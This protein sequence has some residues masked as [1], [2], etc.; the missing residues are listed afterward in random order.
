MTLGHVDV[1]ERASHLFDTLYVGI[2]FN[3][4]KQG[5]LAIEDREVALKK[6][7]AHLPNVS[8]FTTQT[9]L[10]VDVAKELGVT[11]L[12][13]GLRGAEDMAYEASLDFFNHDLAP[14]LDTVYLM[15]KPAYRYI[16]SSRVRELAV[17]GADF[18]AYLPES[19]VE[20]VRKR[21]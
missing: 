14:D 4:D 18:S 19:A 2:F 21:L 1:I 16:S 20:E 17:F 11:T 5:F 6:A 7:L 9:R 10:V 15:A 8:V 3:Q 12:V 13:R